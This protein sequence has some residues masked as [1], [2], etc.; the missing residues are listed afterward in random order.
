MPK[1]KQS[2]VEQ[3][4]TTLRMFNHRLEVALRKDQSLLEHIRAKEDF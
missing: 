3:I 4:A 2:L 1:T